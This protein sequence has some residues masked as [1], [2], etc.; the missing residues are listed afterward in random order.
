[1]LQDTSRAAWDKVQP[2]LGKAQHEVL[3]TI[4]KH[5]EGLTNSEIAH[6]LGWT[7]NRVTPRCQELRTMGLVLDD[8][9]RMCRVT[10]SPAHAW[11]AKTPVLPPAF[12][13]PEKVEAGLWES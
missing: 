10:N 8:G 7:I 11:K 3:E 4:R 1:M 2:K 13:K 6:Y 9:R 5:T 12:E